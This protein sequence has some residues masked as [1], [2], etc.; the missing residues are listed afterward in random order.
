MGGVRSCC[1]Q[2]EESRVTAR[3]AA[4]DQLRALLNNPRW[5]AELR[6]AVWLVLVMTSMLIS[7]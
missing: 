7:W 1:L 2:L 3:K 6:L 5:L 4:E